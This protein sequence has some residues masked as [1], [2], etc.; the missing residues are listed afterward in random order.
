MILFMMKEET[1]MARI[2]VSWVSWRVV[3][4]LAPVPSQ[5]RVEVMR[6]SWPVAPFWKVVII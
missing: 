6:E 5:L 2:K 3:N 1:N 4:I